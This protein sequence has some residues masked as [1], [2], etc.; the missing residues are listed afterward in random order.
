MKRACLTLEVYQPT[1]C[2]V[3]KVERERRRKD[4]SFP[5]YN[6]GKYGRREGVGKGM[7]MN[8]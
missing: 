4:V 1:S 2:D 8:T 5:F 6:R 7:G 3:Y